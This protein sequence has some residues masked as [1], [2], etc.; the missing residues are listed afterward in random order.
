MY[1]RKYIYHVYSDI[2]DVLHFAFVYFIQQYPIIISNYYSKLNIHF[3][4]R[5]RM[6]KALMFATFLQIITVLSR[7]R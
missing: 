1:L 6:Y 4:R 7:G 3:M 2:A 5:E